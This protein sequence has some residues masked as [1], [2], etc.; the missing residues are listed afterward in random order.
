LEPGGR[1]NYDPARRAAR[2]LYS[3][4]VPLDAAVHGCLHKGNPL[5]RR[6]NAEVVKLIWKAAQGRQL[7]CHDLSPRQFFIRSDLGISVSPLF[8]FIEADRIKIYWLQPRRRYGL[9][10]EQ[11]GVLAAI[12]RLAF[13]RDDFDAAGLEL[14]DASVPEGSRERAGATYSFSD[15]PVLSDSDIKSALTRFVAAYDEICAEDVQPSTRKDKRRD[16]GQ[17]GLFK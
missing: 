7:F 17:P 14:F 5:G 10:Y 13:V 9:T 6:S 1:F 16:G 3:G 11:M 12:I 8:Y 2:A 15:L 4:E